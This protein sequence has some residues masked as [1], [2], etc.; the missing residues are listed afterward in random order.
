MTKDIDISKPT[1]PGI[2]QGGVVM[3]DTLRGPCL[4][5]GCEKWTELYYEGKPVGRCAYAWIPKLL[6]ELRESVDKLTEAIK[7]YGKPESGK[8]S[9]E[10]E[11]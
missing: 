5:S 9:T 6:I 8:Q 11:G 3:C 7:N 4:K 2:G 10:K 1:T